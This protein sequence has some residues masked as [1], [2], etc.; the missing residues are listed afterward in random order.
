MGINAF[1]SNAFQQTIDF[2]AFQEFIL[3]FGGKSNWKPT[4]HQAAVWLGTRG[5]QVK[6]GK[7][8]R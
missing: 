1:Q 3:L 2:A 8:T 4:V 5:S 7:R 6:Y